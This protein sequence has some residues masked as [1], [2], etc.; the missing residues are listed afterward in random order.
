MRGKHTHFQ[1]YPLSLPDR[2]NSEHIVLWHAGEVKLPKISSP[3]GTDKTVTSSTLCPQ[4]LL[5]CITSS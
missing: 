3:E 2:H 4:M 5:C 1:K